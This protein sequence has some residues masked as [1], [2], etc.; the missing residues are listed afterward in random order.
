MRS[1]WF[2]KTIATVCIAGISS[3]VLPWV[4]DKTGRVVQDRQKERELK[5][6]MSDGIVH[7][8]TSAI[9]RAEL[10]ASG[11]IQPT[12]L[13]SVMTTRYGAALEDWL[14]A[15][16]KA[17][18]QLDTYVETDD[19]TNQRVRQ[20]WLPLFSSVTDYVRLSSDLEQFDRVSAVE[21]IRESLQAYYHDHTQDINWAV[22]GGPRD[23]TAYYEVFRELGDRLLAARDSLLNDLRS[24]RLAGFSRHLVELW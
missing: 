6:S 11:L 23:G 7:A 12:G 8:L 3:L 17:G 5:V 9:T 4:L 15:S 20:Q 2:K 13:E 24:A 10:F 16:S 18:A 22:L 19:G 21:R 14:A 1:S